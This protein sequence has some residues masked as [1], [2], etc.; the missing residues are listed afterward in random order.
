MKPNT[1]PAIAAKSGWT[2]RLFVLGDM[3]IA[4]IGNSALYRHHPEG[5]STN[6]ACNSHFLQK[7]VVAGSQ[8]LLW[9]EARTD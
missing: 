6:L 1:V 7:A 9:V 4:C 5:S 3:D 2:G 8:F